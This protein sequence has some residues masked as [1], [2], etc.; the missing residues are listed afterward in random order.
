MECKCGSSQ[1]LKFKETSETV[2]IKYQ[3]CSYCKRI[4]NERLYIQKNLLY[5]G[6]TARHKFNQLDAR[7]WGD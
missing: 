7:L 6:T 1:F 5:T 4:T 3:M 2:I